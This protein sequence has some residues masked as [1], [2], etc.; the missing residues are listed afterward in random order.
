MWLDVSTCRYCDEGLVSSEQ[1]GSAVFSIEKCPQTIRIAPVLPNP[2]LRVRIELREALEAWRD[3]V[4][5]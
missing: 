3:T 4:N 5:A 1:G 2:S